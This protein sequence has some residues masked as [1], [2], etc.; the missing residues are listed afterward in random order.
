[1]QREPIFQGDG[2]YICEDNNGE[3]VFIEKAQGFGVTQR[4]CY[5]RTCPRT[6]CMYHDRHTRQHR[7]LPKVYRIEPGK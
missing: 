7:K 3:K 1:M 6:E 5:C 4:N 2:W